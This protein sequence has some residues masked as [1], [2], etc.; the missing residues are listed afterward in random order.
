[1]ELVSVRTGHDRFEVRVTAAPDGWMRLGRW[2]ALSGVVFGLLLAVSGYHAL[3]LAAL[4]MFLFGVAAEGK[5]VEQ[6]V[7]RI[8]S[9]GL[10][11][12]DRLGVRRFDWRAIR[13]VARDRFGVVVVTD[14]SRLRIGVDWPKHAID[15]LWEVLSS[16]HLALPSLPSHEPPEELERLVKVE[17]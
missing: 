8:D 7:V 11:V 2:V 16:S 17:R 12:I 5:G 13:E 1:M 4:P 9:A 10:S 14:N 3:A 15:P 6:T